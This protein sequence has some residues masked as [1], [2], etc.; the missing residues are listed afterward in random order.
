[1]S[2]L[3]VIATPIGNL[4]DITLRALRVLKEVRLI[5]AE[6][7]R[8]ARKLLSRYGVST[9]LTSFHEHNKQSKLPRL[10]DALEKGDLALVS[11]AGTPA[12]SD[13]GRE[14][15]EAALQRGHAV[16]PVP[17]PSAVTA[18]LAASGLPAERFTFVGFLPRRAAE[19]RRLLTSLSQEPQTLVAFEAPHRLRESLSDILEA[20]GD[21]PVTVCREMTKLH[22]ELFR[23]TVRE[24]LERFTEPRGEFTLVLGGRPSEG[25]RKKDA[26]TE[27]ELA[28]ARRELARLKAAGERPRAAVAQVAQSAG[29]PRRAV[30]QLW[31]S[32]AEGGLRP[33]SGHPP[34]L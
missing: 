20:L 28:R 11:E 14:L 31:L 5:A 6:D 18:A 16:V 27:E 12:V 22:E 25:G 15:V 29:L 21:R 10:L 19:R 24:A 32:L 4:E 7:T 34:G 13:P 3:F 8:T 23:G 9:P 17:G 26:P 30:Y 33:P 1:M 2:T